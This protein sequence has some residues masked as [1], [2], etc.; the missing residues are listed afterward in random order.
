MPIYKVSVTVNVKADNEE[1]ARLG[2][3]TYIGGDMGIECLKTEITY[4]DEQF[5]EEIKNGFVESEE[6]DYYDW[7][8]SN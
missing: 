5:K 4:T 2:A 8:G 7:D 1:N 3:C 6:S